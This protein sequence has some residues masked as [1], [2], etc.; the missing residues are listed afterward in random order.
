MIPELRR[1]GLYPEAPG[2]DTEPTTAREKV[3]GKGQAKLRE[4]HIGHSYSYE[5]YKEDEPYVAKD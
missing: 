4:D 5:N 3:Y 2:E 1:R